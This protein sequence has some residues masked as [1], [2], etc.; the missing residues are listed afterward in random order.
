[1]LKLFQEQKKMT[2]NKAAMAPLQFDRDLPPVP[3]EKI[4]ILK[5]EVRVI[6]T[7]PYN[8]KERGLVPI[9]TPQGEIM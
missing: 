9:P 7:D 5:R 8:K 6:N 4:P 3:I 2:A 1:M